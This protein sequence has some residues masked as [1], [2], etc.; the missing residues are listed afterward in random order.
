MAASPLATQTQAALLKLKELR[1]TTPNQR[2][3]TWLTMRIEEA[4]RMLGGT[5]EM[6]RQARRLLQ[7]SMLQQ[8]TT[9]FSQN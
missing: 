4:E 9:K 5:I 2:L 6:P 1:D 3:R 8:S 7:R